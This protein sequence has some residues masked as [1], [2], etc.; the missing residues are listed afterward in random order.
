MSER[1]Q[2]VLIGGLV[3]LGMSAIVGLLTLQLNDKQVIGIL[4]SVATGALVALTG[5]VAVMGQ[6]ARQVR[7]EV[8]AEKAVAAASETREVIDRIQNQ[9]NGGFAEMQRELSTVKEE[10]RRHKPATG[11]P[12]TDE[13]LVPS[14]RIAVNPHQINEPKRPQPPP[15]SP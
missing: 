4:P 15:Y 14:S 9:T 1:I 3:L 8:N 2:I 5:L 7:M 10:L 11:W 6:N 12:D 13:S